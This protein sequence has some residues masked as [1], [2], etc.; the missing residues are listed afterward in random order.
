[1]FKINFSYFFY[2]LVKG[3]ENYALAH[4]ERITFY[5]QL[6]SYLIAIKSN[7]SLRGVCR[8]PIG[9]GCDKAVRLFS[10]NCHLLSNY[11]PFNQPY[12][13]NTKESSVSKRIDK[14]ASHVNNHQQLIWMTTL[15]VYCDVILKGY[16]ITF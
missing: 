15:N 1:M 8:S 3:I 13:I 16:L 7:C 9:Y 4:K 11:Q 12:T 14:C 6:A 2:P 5:L 10:L